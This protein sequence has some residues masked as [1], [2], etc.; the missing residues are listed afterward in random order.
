[1]ADDLENLPRYPIFVECGLLF[2]RIE[3]AADLAG[4]YRDQSQI[5]KCSLEAAK[6]AVHNG[7]RSMPGFPR[8]FGAGS[9]FTGETLG[10]W[11]D[12]RPDARPD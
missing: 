9:A 8:N 3:N 1:M 11:L 2:G 12:A 6:A 4:F 10:E 5:A 7:L